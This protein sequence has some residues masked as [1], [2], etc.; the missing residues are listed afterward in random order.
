MSLNYILTFDY[1]LFGSGRGCVFKHLVE[2]TEKILLIL[3]RYDIKATFFIEQLEVK[4]ILNRAS[5]NPSNSLYQAEADAIMLQLKKMI[6]A[7]H[8]LQL[9][10]HPQWFNATYKNSNWDL[11]FN[12]WRFSSLPLTSTDK[13]Q[14]A[15]VSLLKDGK[16]YLESLLKEFDSGYRCIGFRAGGYNL[17]F[18][19]AS[20]R[21]LENAGLQYDSSLCPGYVVST[22]LSAFDFSAFKNHKPFKLA[23]ELYELP[24]LTA[25]SKL[26]EKLS[27]ARVYSNLRNRKLKE[28]SG[29]MSTNSFEDDIK[30]K[31]TANANFDVCL[32]SRLE[33]SK[34]IKLSL[35]ADNVPTTLIGHPKDYSFFSNFELIIDKILG[36]N[37]SFITMTNYH[38][39]NNV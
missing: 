24:L 26:Y 35:D 12:W 4:S 34:F 2:P 22:T 27:L 17:G 15:K 29:G 36:K 9:H 5:E 10:L 31:S 3:E 11:N 25:R 8:D 18:N 7:G 38:E 1:E 37:G 13:A 16:K 30:G 6:K 33:I 21:A 14:P 32:S 20:V 23:E 39:A 28:V 19:E